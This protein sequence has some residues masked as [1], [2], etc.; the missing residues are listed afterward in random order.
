MQEIL[1]TFLKKLETDQYYQTNKLLLLR[2]VIDILKT[3]F[4]NPISCFLNEFS[5]TS[6]HPAS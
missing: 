2:S 6:V 4:F 5:V 1:V 3:R